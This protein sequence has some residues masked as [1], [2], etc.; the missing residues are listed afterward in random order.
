VPKVGMKPL[1]K[2]QLIDATI[3]T[4]HEVSFC[5]AT[6]VR[7]ARRAGLSPGIIAH[8]FG[9]KDAL[10]AATMR[11]LLT[12]LMRD[13]TARLALARTPLARVEAVVAANFAPAQFTPPVIAAW[14]AFWGQAPYAPELRRINRVYMRRTRSNLAHALKQTT[15]SAEADRIATLA[16]SLIDGIWVRAALGDGPPAPERAHA[17]VMDYVRQALAAAPVGL[18]RDGAGGARTGD[19][20][21]VP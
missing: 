9:G 19:S 6:L 14:F 18:A 15:G 8:Y 2:R 12:D 13:A 20:A 5:E 7:I 21:G 3:A 10:L 17:L 1:R 11:Q 16:A 4:I